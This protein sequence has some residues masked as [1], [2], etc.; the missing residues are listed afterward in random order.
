MCWARSGSVLLPCLLLA[1]VAGDASG[2][3]VS[4]E[5]AVDLSGVIA[6]PASVVDVSTGPP[7]PVDLGPLPDGAQVTAFSRWPGVGEIFALGH[8]LALPGGLTARPRDLVLWDG[9]AYQIGLVGADNGIPDGV[10]IDAFALL[11]ATGELWLS[12]DRTVDFLG[13]IMRDADVIDGSSASL[14]FDSLAA[15]V[16]PGMD[17]DAVSPAP[18]GGGV[19]LSF[20][21]GGSLGGVTFAD[22]DVLEYDAV[23]GTW[24]L[25]TNASTIDAD[26]EASDLDAIDYVPEPGFA[27]LVLPG[28]GLLAL[29]ASRRPG[30]GG[31]GS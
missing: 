14:V 19:L 22:E 10:R 7:G 4:A 29:F 26:F 27:A 21:V 23:G 13:T 31:A 16:P 20:D 6:G 25:V 24:S 3:L 12:F 28:L 9:V 5:A 1:L 15:G 18:A 30:A 2:Q 17:V 8:T 11:P